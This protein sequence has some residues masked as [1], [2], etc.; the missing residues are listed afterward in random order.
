MH[1]ARNPHAAV[2]VTWCGFEQRMSKKDLGPVCRQDKKPIL[3]FAHEGEISCTAC[4]CRA[5]EELRRIRSI[6]D[7]PSEVSTRKERTSNCGCGDNSCFASRPGGVGTNGG[8]RCEGRNL[9]MSNL[10]WKEYALL[11]EALI[12]MAHEVNDDKLSQMTER[13]EAAELAFEER[14]GDMHIRIRQGYDKTVADCWRA[15]VAELEKNL[16]ESELR[17][18]Q[19][20]DEIDRVVISAPENAESYVVSR[21]LTWL[22]S[23][24]VCQSD[25]FHFSEDYADAIERGDWK[26]L[27]E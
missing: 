17:Y 3:K 21:V 18:R 16:S 23:E 27:D 5:I 11:L 14:E 6:F 24:S 13:A 22:R 10:V 15:K 26:L 25:S 12:P 1:L 9:R 2:L 7:V 4:K 19:A 8:C 20:L